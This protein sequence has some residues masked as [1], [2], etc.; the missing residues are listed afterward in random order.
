MGGGALGIDPSLYIRD[1]AMM[2]TKR[3]KQVKS[4]TSLEL[5]LY[6]CSSGS[7]EKLEN[8]GKTKFNNIGEEK[9]ENMLHWAGLEHSSDSSLSAR[10]FLLLAQ[11]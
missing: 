1:D 9:N 10:L 7:P 2:D 3:K 11:Y 8:K 6:S 5:T 4:Q